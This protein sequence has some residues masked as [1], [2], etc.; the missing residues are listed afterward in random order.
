MPSSTVPTQTPGPV[1]A[2]DARPDKRGT[3]RVI[4]ADA[5]DRVLTQLRSAISGAGYEVE[6]VTTARALLEAV[7]RMPTHL[8]ALAID[9]PDMTAAAVIEKV[10][11]SCAAPPIVLLARHGNDPR[12][13]PLVRT[14]A[15]CLFK[16]VESAR[17]LGICERVLRLADQRLREGDWRS[18]PRRALRAS[19]EV[20]TGSATTVPATLV[21]LSARGFRIELAEAIGMGRSV[22]VGVTIPASGNVLTF[23]GRILWEKPLSEGTLAGGDLVSVGSEDERILSALLA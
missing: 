17:F 12:R 7:R 19:V 6:T 14:A 4:V 9:L 3:R 21:N 23:E 22:R 20:D 8:I 2:P 10:H 5:D 18:E 11:A 16:P 1:P 15:A 13:D